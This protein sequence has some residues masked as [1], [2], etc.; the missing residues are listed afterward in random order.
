MP[1]VDKKTG[2]EYMVVFDKET[3]EKVAERFNKR[4]LLTQF[5]IQ[6]NKNLKVNAFVKE[7]WIVEDS[8]DKSTRFGFD[9]IDGG[10][11]GLVKVEDSLAWS[12]LIKTELHGF[13]IEGW[14]EETLQEFFSAQQV[15]ENNP[16]TLFFQNIYKTSK[17]Q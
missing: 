2:K 10:W 14:F 9:P 3:I 7:N 12:E 13:S 5:N 17:Q 1:R 16:L 8:T 6:H 4:L 11:F 15:T